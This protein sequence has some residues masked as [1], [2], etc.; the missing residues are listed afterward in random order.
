MDK[1]RSVLKKRI[2]YMGG[3]NGVAI[4]FIVLSAVYRNMVAGGNSNVGDFISGFQL[5]GA[6]GA[7]AVMLVA[8][9]KYVKALRS[10]T[11][12][13]KVYIEEN[14]ERQKLIRDKIGGGVI[15]VSLG[16]IA[17]ATIIS[18][19]FSQVVFMTLAAVLIFITLTKGAFKLY[20]RTKF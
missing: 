1:F 6:L 20:Y 17:T 4:C 10:E 18:G 15:N 14:D 5:G 19:F 7:E 12:L 16:V 9:G 11:E 3:F 8:I 2:I 13:R